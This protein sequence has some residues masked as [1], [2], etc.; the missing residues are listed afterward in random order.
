MES[1]TTLLQAISLATRDDRDLVQRAFD[2]AREVH[3][4]AKRLSGE[5][6]IEHPL[7][8]AQT[9]AD[10][11]LDPP[12]IAAALLHEVSDEWG[13]QPKTVEKE[14]GR[15][16][17]FL[18][19]NVIKLGKIKYQGKE[20][21][22]EQLRRMV[23][24]LAQDIR[25]ILLKISDRLDNMKT[26]E[27][28]PETKRRRIA[29]ETLEV[30]APLANR[31][32]MGELKGT[33]EDL[34]FPYI[35]PDEYAKVRDLIGDRM[36]EREAHLKSVRARLEKE[37][38]A[39]HIHPREIHTRLKHLYSLWKKLGKTPIENIYDLVALR[40]IVESTFHCYATLGVIH[41]LWT[42]LPGRIRD[43]IAL[44]KPNGYQ[45][46]H[47][48]VFTEGGNITEIQIR[49]QR[50]QD[51]AEH[52]IAAH[53]AYKESIPRDHLGNRFAWVKQIH[54]WQRDISDPKQ[55]LETLK[56]DLFKDRIFVFTPLGD[57]IDLPDGATPIDFAYEIHT[58]LGHSCDAARVNNRL[59]PLDTPLANGDVVEIF[60][61]KQKKPSAKWLDFVKTSNARSRIKKALEESTRRGGV[62]KKVRQGK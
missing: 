34:A 46:L 59:V 31:L 3:K 25:V 40:V 60:P 1:A 61:K 23:M 33:L 58:E 55:L 57:I 13:V 7:R 5:A 16:V 24:A 62:P 27:Y 9:L 14:F 2:F 6:Y 20:N 49:T 39:E 12:T 30:Y 56:T 32:G 51:E 17:A 45:S 35:Y 50:K 38:H 54:E 15:E 47:T 52:G 4:D 10:M 8:V 44:P 37:L 19:A 41:K 42:P 29:L 26:L 53:W 43:F 28:V 48:T 21:Q 18:V 36:E 22:A 11:R